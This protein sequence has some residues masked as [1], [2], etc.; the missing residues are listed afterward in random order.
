MARCT[1]V[2]ELLCDVVGIR[3]LLEIG[4]VAAIAIRRSIL[5]LSTNVTLGAGNTCVRV[6]AC[7]RK[8][9]LT[10]IKR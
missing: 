5:I 1:V 2:T 4:R 3:G 9:G 8:R 7:E 6:R 10:M